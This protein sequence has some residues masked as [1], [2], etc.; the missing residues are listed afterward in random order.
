MQYSAPLA[1]QTVK[2]A[3]VKYAM[4]RCFLP[5][6]G[7]GY[8]GAYY[9][10]IVGASDY[11]AGKAKVITGI[12]APD[13]TTLVHQAQQVPVGRA[14]GRQRAGAAVHGAGAARPTR[15]STTPV[16][17]RPTASTR[18]SRVPT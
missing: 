16:R 7:N 5:Q 11:A 13:D 9:S 2:A 3:D 14:G 12:E 17:R 10:D 6:V 4:E 15:P 1:N 8:A 18:S